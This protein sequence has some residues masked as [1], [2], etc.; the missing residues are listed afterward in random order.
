M[1]ELKE[2][3]KLSDILREVEKWCEIELDY[4]L[5]L[6]EVLREK[7]NE[8]VRVGVINSDEWSLFFV[9]VWTEC[10]GMS[11]ECSWRMAIS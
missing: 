9:I 11:L 3:K 7:E 6:E 4:K 2:F 1:N 8:V 5:R 10:E